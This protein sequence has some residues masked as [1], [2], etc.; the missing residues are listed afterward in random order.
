MYV[1]MYV[2]VYVCEHIS[3][4]MNLRHLWCIENAQSRA[5][6][7]CLSFMII[8]YSTVCEIIIQNNVCQCARKRVN[9]LRAHA[10]AHGMCVR[11]QRTVFPCAQLVNGH[12]GRIL[13]CLGC[14]QAHCHAFVRDMAPAIMQW[15]SCHSTRKTILRVKML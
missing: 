15:W 4:C 7:A 13:H 9:V 8:V 11:V 10:N 3:Q 14:T 12:T 5:A 2:C 6:A 1:C